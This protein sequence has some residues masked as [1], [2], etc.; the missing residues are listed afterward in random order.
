MT[1]DKKK[2]L[3]ESKKNSSELSHQHGRWRGKNSYQWLWQIFGF[4]WDLQR[5]IMQADKCLFRAWLCLSFISPFPIDLST[6]TKIMFCNAVGIKIKMLTWIQNNERGK[7]SL[8][9]IV[10]CDKENISLYCVNSIN[11]EDNKTSKTSTWQTTLETINFFLLTLAHSS[12]G[13]YFKV[14]FLWLT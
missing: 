3:L 11:K 10:E 7:E 9:W 5:E 4:V 1:D 8:E 14:P 13:L 2:S 6:N 12:L